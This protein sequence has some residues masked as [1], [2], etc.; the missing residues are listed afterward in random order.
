MLNRDRPAVKVDGVPLEAKN[1]AAAQAVESRQLHRRLDQQPAHAVEQ[2]V[3]LVPVVEARLEAVLPGPVHFVRGVHVD[4]VGLD[5]VLERSVDDG[6][7]MDHG[8][9]LHPL[10][11]R[12]VEVLNV[13]GRQSFQRHALLP[14]PRQKRVPQHSLVGAVCRDGDGALRNLQPPLQ[15]VRK[16]LVRRGGGYVLLRN[17][18]GLALLCQERFG[19]LFVALHG[20]P[21]G[22]PLGFA[23]IA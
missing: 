5:R 9:R 7:V 6:V 22:N 13:P 20:I 17:L 23:L 18:E 3:H 16:Q 2:A 10:H 21:R 19:L 8:I 12:G 4:Q 11:L 14:E 1:L 15:I